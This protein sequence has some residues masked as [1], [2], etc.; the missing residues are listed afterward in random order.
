MCRAL[1]RHLRLLHAETPTVL[2][3]AGATAMLHMGVYALR[4]NAWVL[5]VVSPTALRNTAN[6]KVVVALAAGGTS[7]RNN[8][9][10]LRPHLPAPR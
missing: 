1:H 10:M 6:A 4:A 7:P 2:L 8:A 9:R 5:A 3:H